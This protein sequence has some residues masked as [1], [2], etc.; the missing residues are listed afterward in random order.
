SATFDTVFDPANVIV[1]AQIPSASGVPDPSEVIRLGRAAVDVQ[2]AAVAERARPA[3]LLSAVP[4][5]GPGV[6]RETEPSSAVTS[7]WLDNGVRGHHRFMDQRRGEV[8]VSVTVAGGTIEE[9]ATT[10]GL[11]EAAAQAWTKAATSQL[12][13]TDIRDLLPGKRASAEP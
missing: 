1:V 8:I 13:S 5:A 7:F 2:P 6:T 9:T 4:P 12:R 3:S 10:R 11:T